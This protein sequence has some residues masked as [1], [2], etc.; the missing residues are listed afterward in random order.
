MNK[1]QETKDLL[2]KALMKL[3]RDNA[4]TEIRYHLNVAL[5]KIENLE[6]KRNK[7]EVNIQKRE[8]VNNQMNYGLYDPFKAVQAID[9]EIAKEKLRLENIKKKQI[10]PQKKEDDTDE[11]Q[12]VFG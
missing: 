6:K 9:D 10:E 2:Q 4:S 11:F 1:T 5:Q 12:T 3:P 8:F 7:R